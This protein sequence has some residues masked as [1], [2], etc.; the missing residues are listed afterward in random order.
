MKH[1]MHLKSLLFCNHLETKYPTNKNK[2]VEYFKRKLANNRKC[3]VSSFTLTSNEDS[4]MA[5]EVL[6]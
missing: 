4:K 5:L 6:F 1:L 2:H 3:S